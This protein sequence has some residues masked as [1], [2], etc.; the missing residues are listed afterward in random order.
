MSIKSIA[1][2]YIEG[3]GFISIHSPTI[4]TMCVALLCVVKNFPTMGISLLSPKHNHITVYI[5][6]SSDHQTFIYRFLKENRFSKKKTVQQSESFCAL[7]PNLF[8]CCLNFNEDSFFVVEINTFCCGDNTVSL[9]QV[10]SP[11]QV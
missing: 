7:L 11:P 2:H 4:R 9:Q 6:Y 8:L 1:L 5:A 10:P 3:N